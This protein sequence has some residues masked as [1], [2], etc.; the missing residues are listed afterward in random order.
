MKGEIEPGAFITSESGG[1]KYKVVIYCSSIEAMQKAHRAVIALA[2]DVNE[3]KGWY[4]AHC[5]R[6]VDGSEV[7]FNEQHEVCGRVIT[8]DVPPPPKE[9]A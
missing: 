9:Q 2:S 3:F 1:G 7:T 6:G 4:C 8:D 5:Q